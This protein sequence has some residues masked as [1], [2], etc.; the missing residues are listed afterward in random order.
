[1]VERVHQTLKRI[2]D[3]QK[4]GGAQDT[5]Q[6]RLNKALYVY[7]FLNSSAEEPDSPHLQTFQEQ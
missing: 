4:R 6:R 1:M 7:N 2:L 3:Q 5:P